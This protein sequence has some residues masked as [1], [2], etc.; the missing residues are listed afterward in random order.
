MDMHN[1][2]FYRTAVGLMALTYRETHGGS[3]YKSDESIESTLALL[4]DLSSFKLEL[5]FHRDEDLA[6]LLQRAAQQVA[7]AAQLRMSVALQSSTF[8]FVDF[9]DLV[10]EEVPSIDIA[11]LIER[12]ALKAAERGGS[13]D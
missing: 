1:E 4:T 5:E 3:V 9:C 6:A 8:A 11:A 13:T 10:K 12:L 2:D 7:D